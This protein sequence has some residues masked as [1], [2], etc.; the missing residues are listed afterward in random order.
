MRKILAPLVLLAAACSTPDSPTAP[1]INAPRPSLAMDFSDPLAPTNVSAVVVQAIDSRRV[2]VRLTWTDNST[3]MDEFT[4]CATAVAQDGS[5]V[6]TGCVYAS[7]YDL[8]QGSTG[9]RSGTIILGSNVDAVSLQTSRTFKSDAGSWYNVLG[10]SS[11]MVKVT[12]LAVATNKKK[13]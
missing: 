4:T 6:G 2:S 12:P 5:P 9:V 8:P 1:A 3:F 7:D 11:E 10:P 13:K